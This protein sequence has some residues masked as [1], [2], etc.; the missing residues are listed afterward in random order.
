MHV[1]GLSQGLNVDLTQPGSNSGSPD[2]KAK[3]LPLYHDVTWVDLSSRVVSCFAVKSWFCGFLRA[4][5]VWSCEVIKVSFPLIVLRSREKTLG[6][7]SGRLSPLN[8]PQS[9]DKKSAS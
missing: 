5:G 2:P 8:R 6:G 7:R 9:S 3:C 4:V 1:K